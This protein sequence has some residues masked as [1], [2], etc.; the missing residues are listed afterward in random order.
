MNFKTFLEEGRDAP[1]YHGTEPGTADDI[2]FT[3]YIRGTKNAYDKHTG[4]SLTRSLDV[5]LRFGSSKQTNA[6]FELDQRKLIQNYKIEPF[7]YWYDRKL[8]ARERENNK[9]YGRTD[10]NEYE[11]LLHGSIKDLNR[12]ILKID[13]SGLKIKDI[14]YIKEEFPLLG[15]H[16]KL[17]I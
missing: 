8:P 2:I 17:K 11:E 1:L 3:K 14:E 5:A 10:V 15:N 12:Y 4:V 16:P 7:N 13:I 6:A 9:G